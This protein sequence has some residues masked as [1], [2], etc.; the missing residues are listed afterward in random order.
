MAISAE[1]HERRR[2]VY[3]DTD[4]DEEA[5][6]GLGLSYR[7][8][9]AWRRRAGLPVKPS[10][11]ASPSI[12]AAERQRRMDVWERTSSDGEAARTLGLLRCTFQSWR[13]NQG[14]KNKRTGC[15]PGEGLIS[16]EE[17]RRRLDAWAASPTLREAAKLV[18]ISSQSF[19][20]WAKRRGIPSPVVRLTMHRVGYSEF[21]LHMWHAFC[22]S[23]NDRECATRAGIGRNAVRRWRIRNGF[24]DHRHT[25]EY[26]ARLRREAHRG[27]PVAAFYVRKRFPQTHG[28]DT[29]AVEEESP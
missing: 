29:V 21:E 14:L 3:Q 6:A 4:C 28:L 15:G 12:S 23:L 26:W 27:N 19:E 24:P 22:S 25:T 16:P 10:S 20:R 11:R 5:A 17:E 1:E 18:G 2:L 13:K 7:A 8:F 9:R